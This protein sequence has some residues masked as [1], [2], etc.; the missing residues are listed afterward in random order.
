[1]HDIKLTL[2][3]GPREGPAQPGLGS[4]ASRGGRVGASVD[5][6]EVSWAIV[7]A[8]FLN[9]FLGLGILAAVFS[10]IGRT[11]RSPANFLAA[12]LLSET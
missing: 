3:T 8:L 10:A 12:G 5:F 6:P 11:V 2:Q 7:F 4:I 1:L 9:I